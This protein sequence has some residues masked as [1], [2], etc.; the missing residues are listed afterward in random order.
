MLGDQID[1][2]ELCRRGQMRENNGD[3][4]VGMPETPFGADRH[5]PVD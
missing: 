3:V 1:H 2:Q 4:C 5:R